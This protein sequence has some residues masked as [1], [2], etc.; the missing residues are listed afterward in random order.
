MKAFY[1]DRFEEVVRGC[2]VPI[3]LAG[4]PEGADILDTARRAA[5]CGVRGFCFGRNLF[6]S[7]DAEERI[8]R[9]DEILRG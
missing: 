4:G 8:E 6:Q 5:D 1:T 7:A 9:L 2:P 3:I